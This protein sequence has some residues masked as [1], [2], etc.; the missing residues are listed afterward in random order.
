MKR[1]SEWMSDPR[2]WAHTDEK[3]IKAP[4]TLAEHS[5]LC[6]EYYYAYC[7]K[8]G[9][10]DIVKRIIRQCGCDEREIKA[11]YSF[12]VN[13]IYQHDIGKINPAYQR[14]VL[15]NKVFP[16][17]Y[18]SSSNHAMLSAYIYLCEHLKE[19]SKADRKRFSC[20]LFSFSYSI[21]RHHGYLKDVADY[22]D[23]L[24]HCIERKGCYEEILDLDKPWFFTPSAGYANLK[25]VIGD[26]TAFYILNKLLFSLITACDYCATAEYQSGKA[27]EIRTVDNL[28]EL[29]SKYHSSE[30]YAGITRSS[31]PAPST[32][33]AAGCFWKPNVI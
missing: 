8:K 2:Y 16:V 23:V 14:K 15:D 22:K 12:F 4:E 24:P 21:A 5:Q 13:A 7:R 32:S 9:M 3:G 19:L 11:V 1:I 30:I 25:K 18:S 27:V 29:R 33:N 20:F 6:L 26:E 31:L 28:E 10:E 17:S